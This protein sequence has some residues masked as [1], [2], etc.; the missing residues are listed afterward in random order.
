MPGDSIYPD[1]SNDRFDIK[2]A[3]LMGLSSDLKASF[4][5][6]ADVNPPGKFGPIDNPSDTDTGLMRFGVADEDELAAENRIF[7]LAGSYSFALTQLGNNHFLVDPPNGLYQLGAIP[8]PGSDSGLSYTYLEVNDT[9]G[10]ITLQANERVVM[11]GYGWGNRTGTPEYNLAVDAAGNLIEVATGGGGGYTNLTQ[12]V[13][14]NNWKVFYSDG[15]GDVQELSIGTSGQVLTSNG[16][17]S[18]PSWQT[19]T[20]GSDT[21]FAE[22]DLTATG[23]R[24]HTFAANTAEITFNSLAGASGFKLSSTSTAA[25]SNAQKL[26]H[27]ALSGANSN[28][29]Q[30]TYAVYATNIHSGTGATNIAVYGEAG[31]T[32]V[33]GVS[34]SGFGVLGQS[35]GNGT[36]GVAG[37]NTT[38]GIGVYGEGT[39]RGVHGYSTNG[40]AVYGQGNNGYGVLALA[41]SGIPISAEMN[42]SNG[43]SVFTVLELRRNASAGVSA[44]IG[45]RILMA[46]ETST[47]A[48]EQAAELIWN[49]TVETHASRTS[50][51]IMRGVNNTTQVD[52]M[53]LGA[54]GYVQLRPI[55]ATAA[56][57][58]TPAEAMLVFVSN[59]NGTFTA[60]GLWCY[61]NGAWVKL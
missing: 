6:E 27:V 14:Q 60:I 30:T 17:S 4:G 59:T 18:A 9:D 10:T 61:E 54:E 53:I 58:L 39:T 13:D 25:A 8:V 32:G 49:W 56:S 12:F 2:Y 1:L 40:P 43:S 51:M 16:A 46:A 48:D 36:I 11:P 5:I 26:L 24:T 42:N 21:N 35:T 29:S 37:Y 22:D 31:G 7:D 34:N 41:L 33:W 45:G 28:N 57:A 55:T 23:N 50:Q 20:G 44:G 38:N 47:T 15:N 3:R 52:M 19:P